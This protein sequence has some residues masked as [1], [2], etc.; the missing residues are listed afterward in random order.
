MWEREI[1]KLNIIWFFIQICIPNIDTDLS[2]T[3]LAKSFLN[4][5]NSAQ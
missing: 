2:F 5:L 4:L 1:I 3:T